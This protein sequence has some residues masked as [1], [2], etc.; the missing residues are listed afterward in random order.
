MGA[1][2]KSVGVVTLVT[3]SFSAASAH[4]AWTKLW[5]CP[6]GKKK[7]LGKV[8]VASNSQAAW[9]RPELSPI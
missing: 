6:G 3:A 9:E 2:G 7:L 4:T 1:L 5:T 8:P